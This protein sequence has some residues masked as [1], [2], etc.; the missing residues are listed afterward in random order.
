MS[1]PEARIKSLVHALRKLR[2][3]DR[4]FIGGSKHSDP[5]NRS[6]AEPL[7]SVVVSQLKRELNLELNGSERNLFLR[8]V[9]DLIKLAIDYLGIIET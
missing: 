3:E 9:D 4:I 5:N 6:I 8:E 2:D 7:A 1:N